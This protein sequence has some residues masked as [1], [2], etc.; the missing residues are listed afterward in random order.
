MVTGVG[1]PQ[2]SAIEQC[3]KIARNFKIPIIADGGILNSGMVAK[4]IAAGANTV[5]VGY[6][7]AGSDE[8]GGDWCDIA[9]RLD[10]EC[11]SSHE[12][13]FRTHRIYWGQ[14]SEDFQNEWFGG[15]KEGTVPEGSTLYAPYSGP[16]IDTIKNLCGGLKSAFTYVGSKTIEEFQKKAEFVRV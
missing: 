4:A 2:L 9:G 6:L 15:L 11:T 14:S 7:L 8:A 10:K 5:M 13:I 16:A 1:Y 3:A 12:G